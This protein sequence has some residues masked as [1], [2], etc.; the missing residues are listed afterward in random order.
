MKMNQCFCCDYCDT[1]QINNFKQARCTKFSTYIDLFNRCDSFSGKKNDE[2]FAK[3]S[4]SIEQ[5]SKN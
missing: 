1:S 5:Y 2:L 4:D 3:I